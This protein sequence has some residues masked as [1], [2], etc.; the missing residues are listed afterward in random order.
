MDWIHPAGLKRLAAYNIQSIAIKAWDL[1]TLT[2]LNWPLR[3]DFF[4]QPKL[5]GKELNMAMPGKEV[6]MARGAE[7]Q[8]K[9]GGP[10]SAAAPSILP[11]S[12]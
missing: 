8:C 11:C 7:K 4:S 5:F 1:L 12:I 6:T 10:S 3:Q 2:A 9:D